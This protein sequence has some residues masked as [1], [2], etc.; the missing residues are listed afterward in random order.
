MNK[1]YTIAVL[2]ALL[3]YIPLL[4]AH[5]CHD[6]KGRT[7]SFTEAVSVENQHEQTLV[8][9]QLAEQQRIEVEEQE[10]IDDI[11]FRIVV[12][13][14]YGFCD[15][16]GR[17][18]VEPRYDYAT[19]F[20]E[21]LARVFIGKT[22]DCSEDFSGKWGFIDKDGN[23][24]IKI[25]YDF[26]ENFSKGL[27][28]VWIGDRMGFIDKTGKFMKKPL[29]YSDGLAMK[30][31]KDYKY[32]FVNKEEQFVINPQ[33]YDAGDF[34]EGLA[35]VQMEK[36]GY[37]DH[38]GR[39][40]IQPQYDEAGDFSEGL[41]KVAI[42]NGY[43]S[44]GDDVYNYGFI[45]KNGNF[46]ISPKYN[47]A[48][49]FS[50]GLAKVFIGEVDYI[51][52]KT[53]KWGVINKEGTVVA[54]IKYDDLGDFSDGLAY[55]KI[56]GRYGF[57]DEK[58][59]MVIPP[60]FEVPICLFSYDCWG[61]MNFSEGLARV[62]VKGKYGFIDKKGGFVTEP[63]FENATDFCNGVA[64]VKVNGKL[65]CIDKTGN[66]IVVPRFAPVWDPDTC[67]GD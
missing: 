10:A 20:S 29:E 66:Y 64:Y 60:Q 62:F 61:S 55:A 17:I 12:N 34:S 57:I 30:S 50:N 2:T 4:N 18:V 13:G 11:R 32:G 21:G 23:V 1:L 59:E 46:V 5:C 63:K 16:D 54:N 41:A 39:Y 51:G 48:E 49:D 31:G 67:E 42:K 26:L 58:G 53:G 35:R 38:R 43:T 8:E 15:K 25:Q 6:N 44:S 65:G 45:D 24:V 36:W 52:W 22:S 56:G 37:I 33:Y 28:F 14:K 19:D 7:V 9:Q 40:V 3:I 27:A 47:Y